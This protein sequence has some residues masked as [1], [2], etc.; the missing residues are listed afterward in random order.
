MSNLIEFSRN[1]WVSDGPIVHDMGLPFTTRMTIVR[2]SDGSIWV[3]SP[4]PVSF[5][6]LQDIYPLGPIKYLVTGTPRHVWRLDH[7]HTLFPGAELW[8]PPKSP[9]TLKNADLPIT[10]VLGNSSADRWTQDLDQLPFRLNSLFIEVFFLHKE[11]QTLIINDLIQ[12]HLPGKNRMQNLFLKWEGVLSPHLEV[13]LDI[14]LFTN[15]K[16]ARLSMDQLLTWEFDKIILAHGPCITENAR[17][18]VIRAFRW[19]YT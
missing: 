1:I 15:R 19:L 7:W 16:I 2:L 9:L 11:S 14:R 12:S 8:V 10:G 13:G 17:D 5:D 18:I 6:T 4:V 3:E